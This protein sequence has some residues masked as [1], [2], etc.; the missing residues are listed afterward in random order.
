M[1][2]PQEGAADRAPLQE[3]KR[4]RKL[5]VGPG[6]VLAAAAL[7]TL[8]IYALTP[9][10]LHSHALLEPSFRTLRTVNVRIA[11]S[12]S[13][14]KRSFVRKNVVLRGRVEKVRGTRWLWITRGAHADGYVAVQNLEKL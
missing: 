10:P 14:P 3:L 13:S 12:T 6:S 4:S 9:P 11:P 5:S 2:L 7:A 1:L 8:A